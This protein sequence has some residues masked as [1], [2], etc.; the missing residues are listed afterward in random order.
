MPPF[1]LNETEIM[2]F[3]LALIRV[4]SYFLAWPLFSQIGVPNP[5]KV[6]LSLSV[7]FCIFAVIPRTGIENASFETGLMWLVIKEVAVGL[8]L[9][10]ISRLLFY[11]VEVGGHIIAVSMGLAS[12]TVFN[13]ASGTSSTVVEKFYLV[14][15]TLLF[16]G[17]NA[18]HTFLSAM[19]E[20]FTVIPIA[21]TGIDLAAFSSQKGGGEMIQAVMVSGIKM[22]APVMVVIFFLNVA[23]GIIGRAVPQINV[24]VTSLPVNILAGLLV[25]IVTLP[26]LMLGLDR[27]MAGFADMLFKLM[28]SM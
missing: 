17:L 18:H 11:A 20:S 16:L 6:L 13:P 28:R 26:A 12:S 23:M 25:M 22:A 10:F 1:Q 21:P 27:D 15:L 2:I 4:S 19:V 5:I 9:G 8:V 14:L 24:L 3:G 7:T